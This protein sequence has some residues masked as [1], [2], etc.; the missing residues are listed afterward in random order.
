MIPLSRFRHVTFRHLFAF[1]SFESLFI[2]N[3]GR[4]VDLSVCRGQFQPVVVSVCLNCFGIWLGP[5]WSISVCLGLFRSVS[6]YLSFSVCPSLSRLVQVCLYVCLSFLLNLVCLSLF[7]SVLRYLNVPWC[8]SF[9]FVCFLL[10]L[11]LRSLRS[12]SRSVTISLGLSACVSVRHPHL[13]AS[14]FLKPQLRSEAK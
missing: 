13:L 5:C 2:S 12:L 14:E 3:D 8:S 6:V 7:R 10:C 11:I 4:C 9:V 1:V